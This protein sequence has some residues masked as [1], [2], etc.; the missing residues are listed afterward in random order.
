M[1][2]GR[3]QNYSVINCLSTRPLFLTRHPHVLRPKD[4]CRLPNRNDGKVSSCLRKKGKVFRRKRQLDTWH[5]IYRSW[6]WPGYLFLNDSAQPLSIWYLCAFL[7]C[8]LSW[9]IKCH[10]LISRIFIQFIKSQNTLHEVTLFGISSF[11]LIIKSAIL[12][13]QCP[14]TKCSVSDWPCTTKLTHLVQDYSFLLWH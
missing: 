8:S 6:S 11:V 12:L 2:N 4:E 10:F 9:G 3:K 1:T 14:T 5:L 13:S 7:F